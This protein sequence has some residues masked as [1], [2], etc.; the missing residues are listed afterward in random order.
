MLAP[1]SMALSKS[2]IR[3]SFLLHKDRKVFCIYKLF[4]YR[5]HCQN[6]KR[7]VHKPSPKVDEGFSLQPTAEYPSGMYLRRTARLMDKVSNQLLELK[8]RYAELEEVSRLVSE[9]SMPASIGGIEP[10]LYKGNAWYPL[11]SLFTYPSSS[12]AGWQPQLEQDKHTLSYYLTDSL[13]Y[14]QDTLRFTISYAT[15]D[16]LERPIVKED[17]LQ[18][19]YKHPKTIE[20]GKTTSRKSKKK[21]ASKKKAVISTTDS[22]HLSVDSIP[23]N[24]ST[25]IDSI[26]LHIPQLKVNLIR[27]E[28][29]HKGHPRAAV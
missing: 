22:T 19:V 5:C 10:I 4:L 7:V 18:F 17:S 29:I 15:L 9:S 23:R 21:R 13:L 3:T 28:G 12:S 20:K 14:Q 27:E 2:D 11:K 24:D 6:T 16:S 1:C 25:L 26:Q 8:R